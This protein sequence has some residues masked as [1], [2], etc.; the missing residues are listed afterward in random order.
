MK[1][2]AIYWINIFDIVRCKHDT[3]QVGCKSASHAL[4]RAVS[5]LVT[6]PGQPWHRLSVHLHSSFSRAW[7]P[8]SSDQSIN[9]D[10]APQHPQ[11]ASHTKVSQPTTT[12]AIFILY[13]TTI[14]IKGHGFSY[15]FL[16]KIFSN[17]AIV[18]PDDRKGWRCCQEKRKIMLYV[19]F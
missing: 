8:P 13:V 19:L 12:K 3:T 9:P 4:E 5:W 18:W 6:W 16:G 15:R 11:S 17:L 1:D 10:P 7:H 14:R 2:Y